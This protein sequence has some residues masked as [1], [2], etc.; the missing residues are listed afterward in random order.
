MWAANS[1]SM[2]E[3]DGVDKATND[4]WIMPLWLP[5]TAGGSPF[6]SEAAST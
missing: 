3:A 4:A 1:G 6:I 2:A 5:D